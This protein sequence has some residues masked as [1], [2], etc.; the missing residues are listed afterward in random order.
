MP[1]EGHNPGSLSESM[2]G[3][4]F[5]SDPPESRCPSL[6][7]EALPVTTWGHVLNHTLAGHFP[8][9]GPSPYSSA[10]ALSGTED[11]DRRA[12]ASALGPC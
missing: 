5:C 3:D 9:W 8:G 6:W 1:P 12:Q 10:A 11:L 4:R 2:Q 7:L